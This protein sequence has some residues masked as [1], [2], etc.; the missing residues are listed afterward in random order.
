MP[1][2]RRVIQ[3]IPR[4]D[5]GIIQLNPRNRARFGQVADPDQKNSY[6]PKKGC[7]RAIDLADYRGCAGSCEWRSRTIQP[8]QGHGAETCQE[9]PQKDLRRSEWCCWASGAS[10]AD[11]WRSRECPRFREPRAAWRVGL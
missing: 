8:L 5:K 3:V 1:R 10:L 4:S 2:G 7:S 11:R 6:N 9:R